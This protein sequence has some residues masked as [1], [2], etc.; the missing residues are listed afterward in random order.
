MSVIPIVEFQL[1]SHGDPSSATER[2]KMWCSRSQK[3]LDISNSNGAIFSSYS[4]HCPGLIFIFIGRWSCNSV[5]WHRTEYVMLWVF[6]KKG[7]VTSVRSR[8]VLTP[9]LQSQDSDHTP[10]PVRLMNSHGENSQV[11]H[12]ASVYICC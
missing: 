6:L 4:I 9:W 11:E 10:N 1:K 2:I 3:L 5:D 7:P 8:C 12:T